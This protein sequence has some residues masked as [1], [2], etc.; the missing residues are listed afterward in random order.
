MRKSESANAGI[1][2]F[3]AQN[4]C[5]Y[6]AY[7]VTL[8]VEAPTFNTLTASAC[9]SYD[10]HGT[11][12]TSSGIYTY[13]FINLNGCAS[14]DTL[15]LTINTLTDISVSG[16]P[17]CQGDTGILSLLLQTYTVQRA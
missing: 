16:N 14:T 13:N 10:W 9:N 15:Y 17:I 6:T 4:D 2:T 1:F 3:F 11:T 5:S 12:Y 8:T 7:N